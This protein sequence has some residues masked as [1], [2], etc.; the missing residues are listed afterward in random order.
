MKTPMTVLETEARPGLGRELRRSL[1]AGILALV[2]ALGIGRFAYTPILPAM[3]E[4]FDLSNAAAGTLASSNYL[5]YLLG[6]L[7]AAFMPAGRAR[8]SLL[9]ASLLVAAVS[10]LFVGE[11]S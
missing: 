7:L 10:T 11:A 5:G 3:Q 6:A 9:R 4:R 1:V 8:D 2:V